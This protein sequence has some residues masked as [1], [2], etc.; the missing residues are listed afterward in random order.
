[1]DK[2]NSYLTGVSSESLHEDFFHFN[3]VND[4]IEEV[5]DWEFKRLDLIKEGILDERP[6]GIDKEY[7]WSRI[8][9]S[10]KLIAKNH[11]WL[12]PIKE[13]LERRGHDFSEI[14]IFGTD[15]KYTEDPE[16]RPVPKK[17]QKR[18]HVPEHLKVIKGGGQPSP[19][20]Q[21]AN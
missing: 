12:F 4:R 15:K 16:R 20:F 2:N 19:D 17:K 7:L 21:A 5:I 13:E 3:R 1:M 6:D 14:T 11:K 10:K 8:K 9:V 18:T